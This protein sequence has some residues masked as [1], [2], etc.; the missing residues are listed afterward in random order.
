MHPDTLQKHENA[1][2][3]RILRADGL[4]SFLIM[5]EVTWSHVFLKTNRAVHA[6]LK[7]EFYSVQITLQYTCSNLLI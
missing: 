2:H 1:G 4:F 3:E 6:F 7:G 5:V